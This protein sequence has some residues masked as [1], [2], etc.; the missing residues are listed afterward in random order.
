MKAEEAVSEWF[1]PKK[2]LPAI[3][4]YEDERGPRAR[5]GR[6]LEEA[7]RSK[8][9]DTFLEPPE[10]NDN[11]I[12]YTDMKLFIDGFFFIGLFNIQ[13]PDQRANCDSLDHK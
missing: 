5:D 6:Q 1:I 7:G 12:T 9:T 13:V 4:S 2:T 3:V 11:E 8:K 10:R